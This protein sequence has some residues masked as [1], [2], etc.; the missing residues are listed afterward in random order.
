MNT[1]MKKRGC[2]ITVIT[3]V[4]FWILA[5]LTFSYPTMSDVYIMIRDLRKETNYCVQK[6]PKDN[7]GYFL[8]CDVFHDIFILCKGCNFTHIGYKKSHKEA[9]RELSG[10]EI[11]F[12]DEYENPEDAYDEQ[13][14]FIEIKKEEADK[15]S[16]KFKAYCDNYW[17]MFKAGVLIWFY[18]SF[19]HK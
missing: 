4:S 10:T 18:K 5:N 3:V 2:L 12:S 14:A 17:G 1:S 6:I 13:Y 7:N 19:I 16:N 11:V 8:S 9:L 15:I